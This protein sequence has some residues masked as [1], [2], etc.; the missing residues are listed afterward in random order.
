MHILS[1]PSC[2][3]TNRTG[4]PQGELLGSMYPLSSSSASCFLSSSVSNGDSGYGLWDVGFSLG[5][6]IWWR[7]SVSKICRS[8]SAKTSAKRSTNPAAIEGIMLLLHCTSTFRGKMRYASWIWPAS[9]WWRRVHR[10]EC[11][12]KPSRVFVSARAAVTVT[13]SPPAA[14]NVI[15]F[16]RASS[17]ASCCTSQSKPT[18][19]SS[20]IG[21]TMHTMLV[22]G[23]SLPN[24]ALRVT[25]CMAE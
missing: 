10:L 1:E 24:L 13:T 19:M 23:K 20:R 22:G 8:V 16:V 18:K 2:F 5:V 4:K 6:R 14:V 11:L 17:L 15:E 21:V 9:H 25:L 12:I 7:S 3:L